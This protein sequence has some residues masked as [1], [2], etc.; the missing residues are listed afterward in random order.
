VIATDGDLHK[1]HTSPIL[2]TTLAPVASQFVFI[3]VVE[4]D[5]VNND[6]ISYTTDPKIHAL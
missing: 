6:S 5:S 1:L 2:I 4:T 3:V